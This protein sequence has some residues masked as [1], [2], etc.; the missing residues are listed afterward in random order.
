MMGTILQDLRYGL[1]TL[2]KNPGFSIVAV[3]TLALG[4]GANTAIFSVIN[5]VLLRPLPYAQPDRLVSVEL[6]NRRGDLMTGS[7]SYPT[8]FDL[9]ARNHVFE[10]FVTGRDTNLTLTGFG[11]PLQL[12]VEIVTW[13]LFPALG[14]QPV[15]GRGFLPSEETPGTHVVVLSHRFWQEQ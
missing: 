3:L 2:I 11:T 4:I 5:T 7:L 10:H 9:R 13:D 6:M 8:F 15:L 14:N 12:D 1:R